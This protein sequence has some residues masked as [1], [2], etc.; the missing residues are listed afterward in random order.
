MKVYKPGTVVE[1]KLKKQEGIIVSAVIRQGDVIYNVS[2]T[3]QEEIK[4]CMLY[5]FE[6]T[7]ING[8]QKKII[9]F[10]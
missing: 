1:L 10:K 4:E 3:A 5:E 6:F 7:V 8:N 2:Y 9:G